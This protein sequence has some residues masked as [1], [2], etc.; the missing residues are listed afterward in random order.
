MAASEPAEMNIPDEGPS[1]SRAKPIGKFDMHVHT[2]KLSQHTLDKFCTEYGIPL[3][4]HPMVP[5]DGFTMKDLPDS[6]IGIYVQQVK[7]GG[8]R[9]PF[10][11]FL[12]RV[13]GHFRVHIS[14]LVPIGLNRV[15]LFE[16]RCYS[17]DVV[18]TVPLFRVF[19]RLCKQGH[20]FS[21]ESRTGKRAL[22]CFEE[23]LSGLKFWKDFFFL[24]DRRAIPYAMP[25]R[26]KDSKISD[27]FPE[28]YSARD[29]KRI[30]EK[31]IILRK[32]P[33]SLLYEYGLCNVFWITGHR[34]VIKDAEGRGNLS[35]PFLSLTVLFFDLCLS[36]YSF[37]V[38]TMS[39][40]LELPDLEGSV[41]S[42]GDPLPEDHVRPDRT[43]KPL[44]PE[45]KVP[46]K[47]NLQKYVEV[48]DDD[49]V[50]AREE[51]ERKQ[52]EK[53][54]A[55]KRKTTVPGKNAPK[56]R[57]RLIAEEV[58][59]SDKTLDVTPINQADPPVSK[60]PDANV[61]EDAQ[62]DL[63]EGAGRNDEENPRWKSSYDVSASQ[64]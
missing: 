43:T 14:Q 56:K 44:S 33:S 5:P 62:N 2:S 63:A 58:V 52:K 20:W 25:W 9:I 42:K 57:K 32:T 11:S 21:F 40:Y 53:T 49:V 59:S 13:I 35:I 47:S 34:L 18:P 55:P 27:K 7:L 6:K 41:V 17:L 24:I 28:G 36:V 26:H 39:E 1:T 31:T 51:K 23:Q 22:K 37:A 29:A 30:A 12:L 54:P 50:A 8:I 45:K 10:S 61:V 19:Y 15:T 48:V 16:V 64:G 4:L 60:Q 3:D 38:I 46:A